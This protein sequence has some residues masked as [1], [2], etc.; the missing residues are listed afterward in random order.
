MNHLAL[1]LL[2]SWVFAPL[3]RWAAQEE[4]S[5]IENAASSVIIPDERTQL[6]LKELTRAARERFEVEPAV[7]YARYDELRQLYEGTYDELVRQL[8]YYAVAVEN[9]QRSE[10]VEAMLPRVVL[11][12]LKIPNGSVVSGAL[13]HIDAQDPT[14]RKVAREFLNAFLP[15]DQVDS[16]AKEALIAIADSPHWWVR[17]YV[18]EIMKRHPPFRSEEVIEALIVDEEESVRTAAL[19]IVGDRKESL[20]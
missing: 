15:A 4:P 1:A 10:V 3:Q 18:A 2:L 8:L 16:E 6:V 14:L 20:P 11:D 17:L 12:F 13:P 7:I 19:S 9:N 5:S